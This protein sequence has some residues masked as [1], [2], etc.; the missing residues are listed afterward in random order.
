MALLDRIECALMSYGVNLT[1]GLN[2][3]IIALSAA[4][5]SVL[6]IVDQLFPLKNLCNMR[7]WGRAVLS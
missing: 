5:I 1:W 6:I 7:V 3:L 4:M 2:I